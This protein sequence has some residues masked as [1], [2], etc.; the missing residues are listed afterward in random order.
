MVHM[1]KSVYLSVYYGT[2]TQVL[3]GIDTSKCDIVT[4][5][6][7]KGWQRFGYLNANIPPLRAEVYESK[8]AC[9]GAVAAELE[10][11]TWLEKRLKVMKGLEESKKASGA[12]CRVRV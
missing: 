11:M 8:T 1:P 7:K 9:G 6:D 2:H 12:V 3:R 4:D 10:E 5:A